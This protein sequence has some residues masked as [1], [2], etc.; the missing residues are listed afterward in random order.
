MPTEIQRAN[1]KLTLSLKVNGK[2]EDGYHFIQSEMVT[3]DFCD[4]LSFFEGDNLEIINNTDFDLEDVLSLG[5]ENLVNK[6]LRMSNRK[7]FVRLEKNIPP[8]AGL[9]GGS[10]NAAAVLRWASFR[11]ISM[12]SKLGS[13]VAFCLLGGRAIVE[14]VG[15]RITPLAY[16]PRDFT[17]LIPPVH[18]STP[19]VYSKWDELYGQQSFENEDDF[20]FD[21]VKSRF[22]N[23]LEQAALAVQPKLLA[24]KNLLASL[25]NSK[26]IMA[27]SGS[28]FFVEG[29]FKQLEGPIRLPGG[30]GPSGKVII[31]RTIPSYDS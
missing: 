20:H 15:E 24:W 26:P 10:A 31:A 19:D 30:E 4:V 28:S 9:G 22:Q 3:L 29:A 12:S 2:R 27:G 21:V 16:E 11:N 1:A 5:Q 14:G 25:T 8:G 17:L 23:D 18:V 7:A 6:A 13:D